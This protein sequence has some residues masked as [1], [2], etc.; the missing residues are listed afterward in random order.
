MS[1]YTKQE[2]G[3]IIPHGIL[4]EGE[5]VLLVGKKADM[6]STVACHIIAC[7]TSGREFAEEVEP[8]KKGR[9]ILFNSERSVEKVVR[10]RLE[11][12]G[13]VRTEC[14]LCHGAEPETSPQ[15]SS[16]SRRR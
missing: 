9:V 15:P 1:T 6:K 14:R 12:A 7:V 3:E 8:A 10:P 11:A 13:V 4:P 16:L 5:S 2:I